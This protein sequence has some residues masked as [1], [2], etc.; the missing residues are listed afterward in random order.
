MTDLNY[1]TKT[2]LQ[3]H[4]DSI[5]DDI[6]NGTQ[7]ECCPDCGSH[8]FDNRCCE[9][10]KLY[11]GDGTFLVPIQSGFE[12]LN[13]ALDIEFI[14]SG[15]REYIGARV[16]VSFGGPNIWINTRTQTVEGFWASDR[17]EGHYFNDPMELDDCCRQIW[18]AE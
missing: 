4:C 14:V 17:A 15:K 5:A 3:Q 11:Q 16:L 6:H 18:E 2:E 9:E 7:Y 1:D 13:G 10:F 12:Y 8:E